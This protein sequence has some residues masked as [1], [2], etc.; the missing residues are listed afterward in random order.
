[1]AQSGKERTCSKGRAVLSA[2][3]HQAQALSHLKKAYVN[4]AGINSAC[5]VKTCVSHKAKESAKVSCE[6]YL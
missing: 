3:N 6:V 1:M 2:E 5:K 4:Q